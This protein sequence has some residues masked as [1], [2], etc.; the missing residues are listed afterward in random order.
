[1]SGEKKTTAQVINDVLNL[2]RNFEAREVQ[3]LAI[4]ANKVEPEQV[5]DVRLI[6]GAQLPADTILAI[7]PADKAL[8]NPTIKDLYQH[9]GGKLLFGEEYLS[10]QVDNFVT[11]AMHVPNFLNHI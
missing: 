11:G 1:M 5:D 3:V 9:L 4:V 2:L 6:L 10:N 7:I 8:Q